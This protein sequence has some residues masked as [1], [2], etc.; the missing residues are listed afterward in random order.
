MIE[1][2]IFFR[3]YLVFTFGFL[4]IFYVFME[5]GLELLGFFIDQVRS[6]RIRNLIL[7]LFS[8]LIIQYILSWFVRFIKFVKRCFLFMN[9]DWK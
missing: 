9:F 1:D 2:F 8:F 4:L 6:F 7:I 3:V 5:G